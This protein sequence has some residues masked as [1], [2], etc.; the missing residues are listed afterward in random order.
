M[1]DRLYAGYDTS[2]TDSS[3]PTEGEEEE[4]E[5]DETAKDQLA[6]E[7]ATRERWYIITSRGSFRIYWDSFI[8]LF[9][10]INGIVLPLQMAFLKTFEKVDEALKEE[11][12]TLSIVSFLNIF[13]TLT[14]IVF[15]I[16]IVV[17]FMSSF[18][19]V[20]TGDEI[21]EIKRIAANYVFYQGNFWIDFISTVPW[22]SLAQSS[23]ASDDSGKFLK[24]LGILKIV[25]MFRIGKVIADLNY[26]QETKAVLKVCKMVF[27]LIMYIHI[28]ACF[29]WITFEDEPDKATWVP[30][31]D[32]I[33][34]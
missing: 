13:D 23:G 9:A 30:Q 17:A 33:Y 5:L 10:V 2:D 15:A 27:Y 19:N 22:D 34:A 24:F 16:D 4:Q 28:I 21:F 8:I 32:Y 31:V 25:R 6:L 20:S 1:K 29:L 26:T 7:D 18:I 12:S 11:G 14:T 3:D